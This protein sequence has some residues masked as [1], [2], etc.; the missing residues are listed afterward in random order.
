GIASYLR[1]YAT[2]LAIGYRRA[3]LVQIVL[4]EAVYL[5]VLGFAVGMLVAFGIYRG[6][7][8]W[9]RMPFT[10]NVWRVAGVFGATLGMCILSACLAVRKLWG[11]APADL[12]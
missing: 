4:R 3:D 11:A 7:E 8:S 12:F 10:L 5:A 6:V 2:L 1:E 9:T